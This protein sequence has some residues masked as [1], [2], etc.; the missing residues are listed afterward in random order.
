VRALFG[1]QLVERS[2]LDELQAEWRRVFFPL[3]YGTGVMRFRVPWMFSPFK[4][5]APVVGHSGASGALMF[6]CPAW[7]LFITGTVNQVARRSSSFELM[8]RALAIAHG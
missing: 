5:F 8:L 2:I 1:G 3:E 4:R 7:D 6:W